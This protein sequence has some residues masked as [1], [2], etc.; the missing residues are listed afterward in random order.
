MFLSS[1]RGNG[2]IV[3][4]VRVPLR[5]GVTACTVVARGKETRILV[6]LRM[7]VCGKGKRD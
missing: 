7:R 3:G 6:T 5:A 1:G 4:D 2:V